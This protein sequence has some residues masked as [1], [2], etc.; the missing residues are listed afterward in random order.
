MSSLF[1]NT[2]KQ[3]I[4]FYAVKGVN[5]KA[6]VCHNNRLVSLVISCHNLVAWCLAVFVTL[7]A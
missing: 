6:T 4:N 2:E 1:N 7:E 3:T 5:G